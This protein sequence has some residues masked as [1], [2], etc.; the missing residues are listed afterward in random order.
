MIQLIYTLGNRDLQR[1]NGGLLL[2]PKNPDYQTFWDIT[3]DFSRK[4]NRGVS[5]LNRIKEGLMLS[6]GIVLDEQR[7]QIPFGLEFTDQVH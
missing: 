7:A 6:L 2:D 4:L 5:V 1:S 3:K